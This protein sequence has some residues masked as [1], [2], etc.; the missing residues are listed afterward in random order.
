MHR[1][2]G[3][4]GPDDAGSNAEVQYPDGDGTFTMLAKRR[5]RKGEEVSIR[6]E[7]APSAGMGRCH[8][9]RFKPSSENYALAPTRVGVT[10]SWLASLR[11]P[12]ARQRRPQC[13]I[14]TL[15]ASATATAAS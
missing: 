9:P 3:L 1:A 13:S 6:C 4:A 7:T 10:L 12:A 14:P 2:A 15:S 5:I 8:H 11:P